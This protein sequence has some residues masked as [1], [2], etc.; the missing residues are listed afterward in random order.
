MHPQQRPTRVCLK[1]DHPVIAGPAFVSL[2]QSNQASVQLFSLDH[3]QCGIQFPTYATAQ[4]DADVACRFLSVCK[5][6]PVLLKSTRLSYV[7]VVRVNPNCMKADDFLNS[8]LPRF[9]VKRT[10]TTL[11]KNICCASSVFGTHPRCEH[12]S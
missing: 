11:L 3:P 1:R 9:S 10:Q 12:S 2:D 8:L 6:F 7:S 4:T 5:A